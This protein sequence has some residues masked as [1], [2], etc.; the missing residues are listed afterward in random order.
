[1]GFGVT[2]GPFRVWCHFGSILGPGFAIGLFWVFGVTLGPFQ[3][4][5]SLS[6]HF[7]F[8][9]HFGSILG[10]RVTLGLFWV[11]GTGKY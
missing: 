10:S 9:G 4:W 7:G 6:V 11:L 2:L 1:M 8:G 5:G 3:V